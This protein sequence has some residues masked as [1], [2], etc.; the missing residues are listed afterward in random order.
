MIKNY[1]LAT[2]INI[3]LLKKARFQEGGFLKQVKS[4]KMHYYQILDKDIELFIEIHISNLKNVDFNEEK[5]ICVFDDDLG[6]PF[7]E[8]Y[9]NDSKSA[10]LN[11]I[12]EEY[13]KAMDGLVKQGILKVKEK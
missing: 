13:N 4:P 6:E 8:F 3:D 10:Y 11:K 5:N 9:E 7:K 1:R 2:D 12:K